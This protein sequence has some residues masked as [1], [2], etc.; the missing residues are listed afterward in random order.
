M[1][2]SVVRVSEDGTGPRNTLRLSGIATLISYTCCFPKI[3]QP[4]LI[5]K[6]PF[7]SPPPQTPPGSFMRT[8]VSLTFWNNRNG[9]SLLL[10]FQWT[11][12]LVF[13]IIIII[14]IISMS[15]GIGGSFDSIISRTWNEGLLTKSNTRPT[16]VH[17]MM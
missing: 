10:L 6:M 8:V 16:M 13:I 12:E 2:N 14:I 15:C 3:R 17:N 5:Y 9:C 4:V 1:P 7:L 11:V